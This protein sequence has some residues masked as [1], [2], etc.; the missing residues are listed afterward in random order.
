VQLAQNISG[1]AHTFN[2]LFPGTYIARITD[3]FGYSAQDT[4][5]VTQIQNP[6]TI[7][8]ST[9]GVSCYAGSN[10]QISV[11]ADGGL[12][13]YSYYLDG[14]VSANP[15]PLD[16]LFLGLTGGT[17]IISVM[18]DNNCM[19]RDTVIVSSPNY[20]LQALA[21]SKIVVCHGSNDGI[22]IGLAAGGTPGY[23]YS[24]YGPGSSASFSNN[25][26]A[27]G[28]SAGTYTL[29]VEDANGCD[30]STSINVIE[31]QSPLSGSPQVFG[32]QC[33][34]EAT[35]MLIGDAGGGFGPYVYHWM[36]L[37]G[38]TLQSSQGPV[39][40]RDTLFDLA[41][42]TYIL[43][44]YDDKN[45][46]I[47]YTLNVPEPAVALSIDSLSVIE[48]IACYGDSV[49]K[50]IIYKSGGQ[51][52]DAQ[53]GI[54]GCGQNVQITITEPQDYLSS[55]INL[56]TDVSCW[57]D[58]TG[59]AVANVIGGQFPYTYAWD[60]GETNNIATGLWAGW[61]AITFTDSN[62]CTL[63]DSIEIIHLY[64]QITGVVTVLQNNSCFNACDAIATLSTIGGVLP[65]TY[66]WDVQ[67]GPT[68]ANMP[69]TVSGL[70]AGGH[71][72]LV[73]D[74]LGCRQTITFMVT[75]PDEL[76]A[77]AIQ[78]QPVQCYGFDDGT[79]FGTATGGTPSYSFVWDSINGQ[80]GQ[81]AVA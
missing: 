27:F 15:Y 31:P 60:N 14:I 77:Q 41:S 57:G 1:V 20:P 64:P 3:S 80:T 66:W 74:G 78:V 30:T 35:G 62:G 63:R 47:D 68:P 76:F 7:N 59:A 8:S 13:P 45:C 17:Y 50:A 29:E 6:I 22:A 42:G 10:G 44:I 28:L 48:G 25:D 12:L 61:Q 36:N 54:Y 18:D 46:L 21:S 23:S 34:G 55:T 4:I 73:E 52:P 72:I 70:C 79:A 49:G 67:S 37:Q 51:I 24:W 58:S 26:T 69:D 2:N 9:I 32:V 53:Y 75:E 38:D 65:H 39:A 43:H 40:L 5:V 71:D 11:L 16:S 19:Q 56:L 33:K 81:N